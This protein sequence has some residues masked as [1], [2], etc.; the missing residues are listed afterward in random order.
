MGGAATTRRGG[1]RE[2]SRC[3]VVPGGGEKSEPMI[4]L[5]WSPMPPEWRRGGRERRRRGESKPATNDQGLTSYSSLGPRA[6][7]GYSATTARGEDSYRPYSPLPPAPRPPSNLSITKSFRPYY[8][9]TEITL[10]IRL[11][12][13][14]HSSRSTAPLLDSNGQRKELSEAKVEQWRQLACGY[15]ERVGARLGL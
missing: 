1:A 15:I 14:A 5:V 13:G 10:L 7:A 4:A 9:P 12:A 8:S 2:G 6:M 3:A 11:Q